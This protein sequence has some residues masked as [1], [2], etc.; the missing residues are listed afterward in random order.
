MQRHDGRHG[1]EPPRANLLDGID[2]IGVREA[3]ALVA[4][5]ELDEQVVVLEDPAELRPGEPLA[6]PPE[7]RRAVHPGEH[8]RLSG[9]RL[10]KSVH[11]KTGVNRLRVPLDKTPKGRADLLVEGVVHG[12]RLQT[13]TI[14]E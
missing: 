12:G 4:L 5:L 2:E 3:N 10:R 8:R 6:M 9:R 13:D 14:D 7:R 1:L 11:A